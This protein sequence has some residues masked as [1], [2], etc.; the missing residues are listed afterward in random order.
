MKLLILILIF[1]APL[2][3]VGQEHL[4]EYTASNGITYHEGDQITLGMGS[5]PTG[6]FL[7]LSAGGMVGKTDLYKNKKNLV[8]KSIKTFQKEGAEK[9]YFTLEE[10]HNSTTKLLIEEAISS[11]EVLPCPLKMQLKIISAKDPRD[12]LEK[13]QELHDSGTLEEEEYESMK[14][15][16]INDI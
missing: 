10:G 2:S 6:D 4:L 11:C 15:E 12:R 3:V 7:F 1:S 8:I 14:K 5:A 13:L 16:I 9:V